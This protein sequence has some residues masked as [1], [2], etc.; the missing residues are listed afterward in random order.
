MA[1]K[2]CKAC[3]QEFTP[4]PQTKHQQYCSA[5]TCQRER[6]RRTQAEKRANHPALRTSDA[7]YFRDWSAKNPGYWK[8]YRA[9]NP[10]YAE[11]NRHQQRERNRARIAKD[12][13]SPPNTLP[14]GLYRLISA[15]HDTI[16]NEDAWL[17]EI[18]VLTGTS[19]H[20]TD[21]CKMKT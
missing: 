7:Q 20:G 3:G 19:G 1:K 4:R 18:T 15:T 8:D 11:R 12:A 13:L 6:R 2:R 21:D 16:A 14:S 5:P 17:V 9:R 10:E